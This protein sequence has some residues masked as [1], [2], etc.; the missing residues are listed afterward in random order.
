[1]ISDGAE[2]PRSMSFRVTAIMCS[3]YHNGIFMDMIGEEV[4]YRMM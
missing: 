2:F 4:F 3:V 1:M